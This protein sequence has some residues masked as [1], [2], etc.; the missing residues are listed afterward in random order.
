MTARRPSADEAERAAV[1]ARLSSIYSP[2]FVAAIYGGA[3]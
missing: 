2:E 3:K 1:I